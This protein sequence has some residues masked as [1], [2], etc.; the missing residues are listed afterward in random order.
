MKSTG[1]RREFG[2]FIRETE[3]RIGSSQF[4]VS[5]GRWL[6]TQTRSGSFY[7]P[8]FAQPH[9]VEEVKLWLPEK[10]E[11]E[12]VEDSMQLFARSAPRNIGHNLLKKMTNFIA[13][14][15]A[16]YNDT[17]SILDN[18]HAAV[19]CEFEQSYASLDELA[20]RLLS[21]VIP[22]DDAGKYPSH[23]LY[24]IHRSLTSH[25]PALFRPQMAGAADVR[26]GGQFEIAPLDEV[27]RISRVT[28]YV[29]EHRRLKVHG[30]SKDSEQ[31]SA[32]DHFANRAR[33]YIDH[34][35]KSRQLTSFATIGP[36]PTTT[37]NFRKGAKLHQ[38][39]DLDLDFIRFLEIW[40]ISQN[41]PGDTLSATGAAILGAIDR[42]GQLRGQL[43]DITSPLR[44]STA[45]ACLQ[46][47]G[48]IPPWE[49]TALQRL[50]LPWSGRAAYA[51]GQDK[52]KGLA[53]IQG[54]VPDKA[55]GLRK[56]WGDLPVFCIDEREAAEIDDGISVERT[57]NPNEYWLHVHVADPASRLDVDGEANKYAERVATN[58]YLPDRKTFMLDM[59]FVQSDLSLG[60][61]RPCLTISMRLNT[62]GEV[63]ESSISPG[64]VHNIV[65]MTNRG[66]E[67]AMRI[68]FLQKTKVLLEVGRNSTAQ[69]DLPQKPNNPQHGRVVTESNEI[70]DTL[71]D[72]LQIIREVG[73]AL[74]QKTRA[75]RCTYYGDSS[76]VS[77]YFDSPW[78]RTSMS[79][80]NEYHGDPAI[81]ITGPDHS[82]IP[83]TAPI[84]N[85]IE[86]IMLLAGESVAKWCH[87]RGIPILYRTTIP[88]PGKQLPRDFVKE[89]IL[90]VVQENNWISKDI[91]DEYNT[92]L[93]SSR[94]TTTPGPHLGVGLDLWTRCTSP[95]RRF[96]DLIVH[97]QIHAALLEEH[98]S[99]VS[100]IG[101]TEE[102]LFPYTTAQLD[103]LV[104]RIATSE[105]NAQ[106]AENFSKR[107]W[108]LRAI[109]RAWKFG[110]AKLPSPLIMTVRGESPNSD[111]C[112]GM[113]A[114]LLMVV[115][116]KLPPVALSD[117]PIEEGDQFEV[118]IQD[119]DLYTA[120]QMEVIP[121]RRLE[122]RSSPLIRV[123]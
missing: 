119:I 28:E 2:I 100:L 92:L 70:S 42:Y 104:P 71:R 13:E 24:A 95:L 27:R 101:N 103:L 48:A 57:E 75:K 18:A 39:S 81:R 41:G 45:W 91:F 80:R 85:F 52:N 67:E 9:E 66:F 14:A 98:R 11:P 29:R 94:A 73:T 43:G 117:K 118:Q 74:T 46:E 51:V 87:A 35:R 97:H 60:P 12:S 99:G 78:K 89:K 93:G 4:Y 30:I 49:T 64:I 72:D 34:S 22:K 77:V 115:K 58:S 61:N 16:I 5:N 33:A 105:A 56:D 8:G 7:V 83:R 31:S 102:D 54:I 120:A 55:E 6:Q 32:L 109:L 68:P 47:L 10:L 38:F 111:F 40:A 108:K 88:R 69:E 116:M 122:E 26:Q 90:P 62:N 25:S 23:V 65:Y 19:A 21:T 50:R 86:A 123:F 15:D 76:D 113:I 53:P 37:P 121:V 17:A 84:S 110:E 20:E 114:S 1:G 96:S 107:L 79:A 112:S 44:A 63:L 59:D 3:G 36:S 82:D 106:V